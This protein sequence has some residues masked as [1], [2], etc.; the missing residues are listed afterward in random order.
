V[1]EYPGATASSNIPLGGEIPSDWR[2]FFDV[3]RVDYRT[4]PVAP[5]FVEDYDFGIVSVAFDS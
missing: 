5:G 3:V 1:E 2:G 4:S